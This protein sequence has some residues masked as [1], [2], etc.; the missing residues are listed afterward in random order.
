MGK[1]ACARCGTTEGN[2][3]QTIVRG[4]K[5]W[6]ATCAGCSRA[7]REKSDRLRAVERVEAAA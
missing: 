1:V 6:P 5:P 2:V 4:G 3:A 7:I